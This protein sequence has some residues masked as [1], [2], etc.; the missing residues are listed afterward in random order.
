VWPV[1]V[2]VRLVFGEDLSGVGFVHGQNVV[3]CLPSDRADGS[4]AVGIHAR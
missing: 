2:V 4:L 1:A 3:G